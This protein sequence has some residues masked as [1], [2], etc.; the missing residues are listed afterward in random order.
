M[1]IMATASRMALVYVGAK[2]GV[3]R[4]ESVG[5]DGQM[6]ERGALI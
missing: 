5:D 3:K 1:D 6:G 2:F 4:K